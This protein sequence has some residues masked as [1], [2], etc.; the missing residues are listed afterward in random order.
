MKHWIRK[1]HL[2]VGLPLGILF[3]VI[4][5]SGALYTWAPE[6]ATIIYKEN[7]KSQDL[8]FVSVEELTETVEREL[9]NSDFRTVYYRG[10]SVAI[11]V[12]LYTSETYYHANINPYTGG[13]VNI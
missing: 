3:F 1:I 7:V 12:L 8:P 5:L 2:W 11:Q 4:A 13:A 6:I 10:P 9:P